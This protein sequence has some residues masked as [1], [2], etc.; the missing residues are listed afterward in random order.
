MI[1]EDCQ[2]GQEKSLCYIALT[3]IRLHLKKAT[4]QRTSVILG[5]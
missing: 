3:Q 5:N 4:H 1:R 2:L